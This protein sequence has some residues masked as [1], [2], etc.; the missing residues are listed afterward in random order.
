MRTKGKLTSWNDDKGFGFISP[1]GGGKRIFIHIKAFGKLN[2]RPEVDELVTY[3]L[4]SDKQGRPCAVNATLAGDRVSRRTG[5]K[6]AS[7]SVAT[8][9]FFIMIVGVSVFI[10]RIPL[11]VLAIYMVTSLLTFIMYAWDKSAARMGAW[12]TQ[13]STLHLLALAG[14]W[15][16]ALIAQQKLRHKSRKQ[17]FRSVFWITVFLNCGVFAWLF[18]PKGGA[19]LQGLIA[20][21]RY[22]DYLMRIQ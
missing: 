13:E 14:G 8:G 12:R 6:E 11:L 20:Q 10:G 7:F 22:L 9:L 5:Q 16:G 17:S 21:A 18:T 1:I 2:T 15:P 4:S 19:T 3:A